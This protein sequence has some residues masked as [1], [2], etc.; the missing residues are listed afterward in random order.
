MLKPVQIHG[1]NG[2][3]QVIAYLHDLQNISASRVFNY[4]SSKRTERIRIN[5]DP[6]WPSKKYGLEPQKQKPKPGSDLEF[7]LSYNF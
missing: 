3:L 2:E 7:L 1:C 6:I 5:I 4:F